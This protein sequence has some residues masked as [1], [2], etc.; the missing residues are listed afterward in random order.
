MQGTSLL[1][2]GIASG[3]RGIANGIGP[4]LQ[5]VIALVL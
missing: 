5:Q 3:T 4:P 2:F 1:I